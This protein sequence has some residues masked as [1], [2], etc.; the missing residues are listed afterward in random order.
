MR[1]DSLYSLGGLFPLF[2][3]SALLI[4]LLFP[5]YPCGPNYF[6]HDSTLA[7]AL[8]PSS[9]LLKPVFPSYPCDIQLFFSRFNSLPTQPSPP[10]IYHLYCALL[11]FVGFLFVLLHQ[12]GRQDMDKTNSELLGIWGCFLLLADRG[13]T[14]SR[15]H[16]LAL[17]RQVSP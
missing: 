13:V 17:F 4:F 9:Y 2:R 14:Q 11:S 3:A 1:V 16:K 6:C 12:G 15:S 8:S 7:T 10:N 5:P